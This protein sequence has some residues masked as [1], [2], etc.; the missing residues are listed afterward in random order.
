MIPI[1]MGAIMTIE[2]FRAMVVREDAGRFVRGIETS[3]V[4]VA[5]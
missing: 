5:T 2:T 4:M 1:T 3:G